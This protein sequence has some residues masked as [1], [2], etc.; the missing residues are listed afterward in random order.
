MENGVYVRN[1]RIEDLN[2]VIRLENKIWPAGTRATKDKFKSRLKVFP[3]GFFIASQN[4]RLIGVSTSQIINY[5]PKN[6]PSSWEKITDNGYIEKTHDKNGNSV[7]VVSIGAIS[8]SGGGSALIST[9]KQLAKSLNLKFLVLGARIPGYDSYCKNV[10]EIDIRDY[11][12]LKR[13]DS[14]LLDPELRFYTRNRLIL[15][16]IIPN[17]MENDKESRNYGAIMVWENSRH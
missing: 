12:K 11:V 6:P 13:K 16:K 8:R 2:E 4:N 10:K 14:Q 5:D 1:A 3:E 7:Y 9:Q 15:S 17:Y